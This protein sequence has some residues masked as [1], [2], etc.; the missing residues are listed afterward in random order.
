MLKHDHTR[1]ADAALS[2][3]E[4]RAHAALFHLGDIHHRALQSDRPRHLSCFAREGF[5]IDHVRRIIGKISRDELAFRDCGGAFG[6][7]AKRS[8]ALHFAS[9]QDAETGIP[10]A[11]RATGLVLIEGVAAEQGAFGE[12]RCGAFRC[13]SRSTWN[14]EYHSSTTLTAG[15]PADSPTEFSDAFVVK[16]V[17]FARAQKYDASQ[18]AASR[19]VNRQAVPDARLEIPG[20]E[21]IRQSATHAAIE[22]G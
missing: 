11:L 18:I 2:D 7:R 16:F 3:G 21:G 20:R 12:E 5:R 10:A 9:K 4:N 19:T 1:R 8:K 17:D 6:A 14:D 15:V 22:S 13:E